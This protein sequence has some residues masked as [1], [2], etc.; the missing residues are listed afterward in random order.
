M[1]ALLACSF[2]QPLPSD[3]LRPTLAEDPAPWA[4]ADEETPEEAGETALPADEAPPLVLI[5]EVMSANRSSWQVDDTLPD[6]VELYNA[7]AVA[8]PLSHI[9]LTDQGGRVW[10]GPREQVLEP[11]QRVVVFADGGEGD[12]HA[13]FSLD[14]DGDTLALAV[15]GA[16]VDRLALGRLDD[17]VAWARHPDAGEWAPTIAVTPDTPNP[18]TPSATLDLTE[19][20]FNFD[21]VHTVEITLD[22]AAEASLRANRLSWVEGGVTVNG[23][24]YASVGV[25][26]KA[27]VGSSRT[28]DQK[29][30]FKV[31]LNRFEDQSWRGLEGLTLNNMVQDATYVHEHLAYTLYREVGVP[32]PRVAY[33]RV[34]VNGEHFGLYLLVESIDDRFLERWYA[35]PDGALY[36]GAYG[37]DLFAGYEWS[38]D[39]D[40]GPDPEDRSDLTAVIDVLAG[41]ADDAGLAALYALVDVDEVLV[42][43][44]VEAVILHWDGYTTRNNYRLYHDPTTDRFQIIPWGADQT[45][46]SLYYGP[47]SGYGRIF[48]FCLENDACA[49]RYDHILRRVAERMISLDLVAEAEE[50]HEWLL[51][52]L[53][54][55]PRR[56]F[57]MDTHNTYYQATLS[58]IGTWPQ[59]VIQQV[60]AR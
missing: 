60:D 56:E 11:G 14:A 37:V 35:N 42:N 57:G 3:D 50:L 23:I 28:L 10:M 26:L 41:P 39:Y 32:A 36:E 38:F 4:S 20:V 9:T 54:D 15:Q 49:E 58:T 45:F 29:C 51:P 46:L 13:P 19:E 16:V 55:D 17:D 8:V 18:D 44:A 2:P 47:W 34:Y 40:E 31:D 1:F 6:W 59:S 21:Q 48:T 5:N 25:R 7:D 24:S 43:M 27:Y 12:L 33:A 22:T 53:D 30:G 52:E